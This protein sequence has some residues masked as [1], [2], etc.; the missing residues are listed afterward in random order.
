MI[1]VQTTCPLAANLTLPS[2]LL[3]PLAAGDHLPAGV[4]VSSALLAVYQGRVEIPIANVVTED[5]WLHPHTQLGEL[6]V[7]DPVLAES[8]VLVEEMEEQGTIAVVHEMA[9]IGCLM[10]RQEKTPPPFLGLRNPWTPSLGLDDSRLLILQV[11]IIKCLWQ[12]KTNHKRLS[13]HPLGFLNTT[14]WVV[15]HSKFF[16]VPDGA[17]FWRSELPI[18]TFVLGR[19]CNLFR[20]F[21]AAPP[22]P[23]LG[24]IASQRAQFKVEIGNVSFFSV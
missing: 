18:L 19:H 8:S 6:H 5:V 17:H 1:W 12:R 7:V 14:L 15:Q 4:L 9:A 22:T 10:Q 24:A 11:A 2:V 3:E 16:S 20:L 13:A 21:R 23:C